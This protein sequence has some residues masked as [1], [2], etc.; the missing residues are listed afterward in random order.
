MEQFNLSD[1][2]YFYCPFHNISGYGEIV[3]MQKMIVSG[4]RYTIEPIKKSS[5]N[6]SRQ[7]STSIVAKTMDEL[8]QKVI[9]YFEINTKKAK[10]TINQL[11]EEFNK[12]F[13]GK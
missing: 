1:K 5:Q 3:E 13:Y 2:V 4:V 6:H 9:E 8:E 12:E 7:F 10:D 11:K